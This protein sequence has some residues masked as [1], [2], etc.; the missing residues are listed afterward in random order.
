M[1]KYPD[2]SRS[3]AY[4]KKDKHLGKFV[5]NFGPLWFRREHTKEPFQALS[6]S[7]IYQQISGKAA[8]SILRRFKHLWPRK[9][10]LTPQDVQKIT[11]AKMRSAGVSPQK[12]A[13]LKDLAAKFLDGTINPKLFPSMSDEEIIEHVV[14]VKGIGKWT[15]HMF[16]MFTLGRPDVLPTGDLAIQKAFQK[17][18]KLRTKPSPQ[19]M[20]ELAKCWAGHRSV[21]CFYLWRLLDTKTPGQ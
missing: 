7:I 17:L 20:R 12:A 13:Y 9:K 1:A 2:H 21:A 14:R 6:E 19:R 4:L 15:A 8:E 18:F 11:A 5:R 10:F 16:L 3:I